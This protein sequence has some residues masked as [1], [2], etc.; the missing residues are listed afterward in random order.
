MKIFNRFNQEI[1]STK[2][3]YQGW[4]GNYLGAPCPSGV[5][6]YKCSALQGNADRISEWGGVFTL[7][8]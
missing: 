8:R 3:F 2:D 4:D 6:L 1:F 7:L 5:Y